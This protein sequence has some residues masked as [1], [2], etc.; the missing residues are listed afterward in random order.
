MT[1]VGRIEEGDSRWYIDPTSGA[2]YESVTRI[3]SASQHKPWL[4][5]WSGRVTAE[6]AI[7]HLP[8]LAELVKAEGSGPAI[9]WL[10][11][12]GERRRDLKREIGS[13]CHDVI[14]ALIL[15]TPIPTVPEH[16]QG[17]EVDGEA[18]DLDAIIDGFLAFNE[19]FKPEYL[20]AEATVA[21]VLHGYA[22]TLDFVMRC[23]HLGV[24]GVDT[25]TGQLDKTA[26]PQL[27][28]YRRAD[29]IW[30]NH[31]G[32]RAPM[33]AW[34]HAAVLHIRRSY[35]RGY[36]LLRQPADDKAFE[37]FLRARCLLESA[38]AGDAIRGRPLYPPRDDGSQPPMLVEDCPAISR[39]AEALAPIG[40]TD[41]EL[42]S[43][44]SVAG[45]LEI[46]GMG[47]GAVLAVVTELATHGLTLEGPTVCAG[48]NV[49]A[50]HGAQKVGRRVMG[51]C[52]VCGTEQSATREGV[53]RFHEVP[54][55]SEVNAVL[56]TEAAS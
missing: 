50:V 18:V 2:Q 24:V 27:A 47:E 55:L 32:D 10:A 28:A 29:E 49:A 6:A 46:K 19:D 20:M 8:L 42:L 36:K 15:E 17:V 38:Q 7:E 21:N 44:M 41:V 11:A 12:A 40:A 23:L 45:I 39:Y 9:K 31:M 30:L 33:M 26:N 25:K 35:A 54:D 53:V 16:L 3:L 22:G 51:E 48:S 52:S 56:D 4:A 14:E 13:Y 43:C 1:V 37:W 34:D 5:P